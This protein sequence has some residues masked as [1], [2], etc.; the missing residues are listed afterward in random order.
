MMNRLRNIFFL[1]YQF[2]NNMVRG[3]FERWLSFKLFVVKVLEKSEHPMLKTY[4]KTK[5][6]RPEWQFYDVFRVIFSFNFLFKTVHLICNAYFVLYL[7]HFVFFIW[8]FNINFDFM[9]YIISIISINSASFDGYFVG[10]ILVWVADWCICAFYRRY[11]LKDDRFDP[12]VMGNVVLGADKPH[13]WILMFR[14]VLIA[15]FKVLIFYYFIDFIRSIFKYDL[16]TSMRMVF[17]NWWNYMINFK[18]PNLR[19]SFETM[20]VFFGFKK[21]TNVHGS[22]RVAQKSDS[23][24]YSVK[25][26]FGDFYIRVRSQIFEFFKKYFANE[27]LSVKFY[28]IVREFT[29]RIDEIVER[30]NIMFYPFE[31]YFKKIKFYIPVSVQT[32][33]N[34]FD[35]SFFEK[36]IDGLSIVFTKF[37]KQV[38]VLLDPVYFFTAT[39]NFVGEKKLD[40][41]QFFSTK[42]IVYKYVEKSLVAFFTNLYSMYCNLTLIEFTKFIFYGIYKIIFE[43]LC[44]FKVVFITISSLLKPFS[45]LIKFFLIWLIRVS[46][47]SFNIG[48]VWFEKII[49]NL[50]NF[51][52]FVYNKIGRYQFSFFYWL[53]SKFYYTCI[54][55]IYYFLSE[56]MRYFCARYLYP[57]HVPFDV[58]KIN[59]QY[60]WKF[61]MCLFQ[62][63]W[64]EFFR[65]VFKFISESEFSRK[66]QVFFKKALLLDQ[67][68]NYTRSDDVIFYEIAS[69]IVHMV[70][71]FK[72]YWKVLKDNFFPVMFK[73]ERFVKEFFTDIPNM[74]KRIYMYIRYFS[75]KGY[76][77]VIKSYFD[78][79]RD[80][81]LIN[82]IPIIRKIVGKVFMVVL[83]SFYAFIHYV[84]DIFKHIYYF[85]GSGFKWRIFTDIDK[86]KSVY[87]FSKVDY[88]EI[89][90]YKEK[91]SFEKPK[92]YKEGFVIF[93]YKYIISILGFLV[94]KILLKFSKS[95]GVT[96]AMI[97]LFP[98][99]VIKF[100]WGCAK[101]QYDISTSMLELIFLIFSDVVK[102]FKQFGID[103]RL[104]GVW[105]YKNF[106]I[107]SIGKISNFWVFILKFVDRIRDFDIGI[108]LLHQFENVKCILWVMY[109]LNGKI[110]IS[111]IKL[112]VFIWFG[113]KPVLIVI[114]KLHWLLLDYIIFVSINAPIFLLHIVW[115]ILRFLFIMINYVWYFVIVRFREIVQILF[116]FLNDWN[117]SIFNSID[118][119]FNVIFGFPFAVIRL[120]KYIVIIIVTFDYSAI[121]STFKQVILCVLNLLEVGFQDVV[122]PHPVLTY[123]SNWTVFSLFG[124]WFITLW[125]FETFAY[126][127]KIYNLI[128]RGF[129]IFVTYFCL[130]DENKFDYPVVKAY[131]DF[132]YKFMSQMMYKSDFM[133]RYVNTDFYKNS[134]KIFRGPKS[135]EF[136][137]SMWPNFPVYYS[138]FQ[139]YDGIKQHI[140]DN[141]LEI[142]KKGITR[143]PNFQSN[144]ARVRMQEIERIR[145][146][147]FARQEYLHNLRMKRS[148]KNNKIKL[149]IKKYMIRMQ[150]R[151][152]LKWWVESQEENVEGIET[153]E[154]KRIGEFFRYY[155]KVIGK[156][157]VLPYSLKKH[158]LLNRK[159]WFY[160]VRVIQYQIAKLGLHNELKALSDLP[161]FHYFFN[162]GK[163]EFDGTVFVR[164]FIRVIIK[165]KRH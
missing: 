14:R 157:H 18:I 87:L 54:I 79:V 69:L 35:D 78:V 23:V 53:L 153:V 71:I 61:I 63:S 91:I 103:F 154:T 72:W 34:K 24:G 128:G 116:D 64:Y 105:I 2:I 96:T 104:V 27:I 150:I 145:E 21:V 144:F 42:K 131:N 99:R 4:F 139:T 107:V 16:E 5:F 57:F 140:Y 47:Y 66:S 51:V 59:F 148:Y 93:I 108:F 22:V 85:K 17:K 28:S 46:S 88:F 82:F 70:K 110:F 58:V 50:F 33:I 36:V 32:K 133:I 125:I 49:I 130:K 118:N 67:Y 29:I 86:T 109:W 106:Y 149:I 142:S 83:S 43:C 89:P 11:Y 52:I 160:R 132:T 165:R 121:V 156:G 1:F 44:Y 152:Y 147:I 77:D 81:S 111:I 8:K 37:K 117:N 74:Y 124:V 84:Y 112:F 56:I 120:I 31:L 134:P 6:K 38:S 97:L 40:F 127:S 136:W 155:G 137:F 76:I 65:N 126:V 129:L 98:I 10:I 62:T 20:L 158:L 75:I 138:L 68:K 3:I 12:L 143:I 159:Y 9:S 25:F 39:R 115:N 13:K 30:V 164:E 146:T 101:V 113:F 161:R 163:V 141:G 80:I 100:I 122:I 73:M 60:V 135:K 114:L 55:S 123:F 45:Q 94:P 92:F 41:K 7:N 102:F 95:L 151:N 19:N 48:G 15:V 26:T 90:V 162:G 119:V